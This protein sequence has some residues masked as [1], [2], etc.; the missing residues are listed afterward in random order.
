MTL[1]TIEVSDFGFLVF[2]YQYLF[3]L[4]KFRPFAVL[5]NG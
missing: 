2:K 1:T 3:G 4:G 5:E